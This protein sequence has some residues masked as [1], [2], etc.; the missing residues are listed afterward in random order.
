M[1]KNPIDEILDGLEEIWMNSHPKISDGELRTMIRALLAETLIN[2]VMILKLSPY[3]Q[4]QNFEAALPILMAAIANHPGFIPGMMAPILLN[5]RKRVLELEE[6][7]AQLRAEA[8]PVD[9]G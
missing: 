7:V 5:A 1:S 2:P 3:V 8:G 4:A 6:E 9:L